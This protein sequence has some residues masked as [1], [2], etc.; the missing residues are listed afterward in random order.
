MILPTGLPLKDTLTVI[1]E[2]IPALAAVA[3]DP[4]V[5]SRKQRG[6]EDHARNVS[7]PI[8]ETSLAVVLPPRN[9]I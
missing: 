2:F 9:G 3:L 6:Q 5:D 8:E 1:I 4:L 7:D